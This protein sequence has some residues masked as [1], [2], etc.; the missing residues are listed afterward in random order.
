[1]KQLK[2]VVNFEE[3]DFPSFVSDYHASALSYDSSNLISELAELSS[4]LRS[5][6]TEQ[7]N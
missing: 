2:K 3:F 5:L 1:M 6:E 4:N 7:K